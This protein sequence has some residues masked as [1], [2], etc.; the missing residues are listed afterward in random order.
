[1]IRKLAKWTYDHT[2]FCTGVVMLCCAIVLS[3][4]RLWLKLVMLVIQWSI[5]G[6]QHYGVRRRR[7]CAEDLYAG[8]LQAFEE[9]QKEHDLLYDG[10]ADSDCP[11]QTDPGQNDSDGNSSGDSSNDLHNSVGGLV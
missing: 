4:D 6:L 5:I 7:M 2:W 9:A 10:C 1:M 8:F 3:T 11:G